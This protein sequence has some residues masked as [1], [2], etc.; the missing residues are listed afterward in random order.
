[1]GDGSL[2]NGRNGDWE[3]PVRRRPGRRVALFDEA[4][5][6]LAAAV[7]GWRLLDTLTDWTDTNHAVLVDLGYEGENTRLTCPIKNGR[8]TVLTAE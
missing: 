2:G 7:L 3:T 1:V 6:V 8:G 5:E 4:V